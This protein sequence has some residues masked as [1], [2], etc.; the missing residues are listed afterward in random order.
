MC[1]IAVYA[2]REIAMERASDESVFDRTGDW[3]ATIGKSPEERE[4][5][6]AKRREERRIRKE[7]K[8]AE[9]EAR[10]AGKNWGYL[11]IHSSGMAVNTSSLTW[12]I[13]RNCWM[14]KNIRK[15]TGTW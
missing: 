9:K 7:A 12:S 15:S 6:V 11:S 2:E 13:Q 14:P 5:I 8:R 3:F 10:K 4:A 1:N